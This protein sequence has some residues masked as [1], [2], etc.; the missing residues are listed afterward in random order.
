MSHF[1]I[2]LDAK[3]SKDNLTTIKVSSETFASCSDR[4]NYEDLVGEMY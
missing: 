2:D 1:S 3:E 4:I